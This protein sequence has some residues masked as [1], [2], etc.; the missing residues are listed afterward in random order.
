MQTPIGTGLRGNT[1]TRPDWVP[2]PKTRRDVVRLFGLPAEGVAIHRAAQVM[3]EESRPSPSGP[4]WGRGTVYDMARR[5]YVHQGT[6]VWNMGHVV[7]ARDDQGNRQKTSR[8]KDPRTWVRRANAHEALTTD[9]VAA[10]VRS[11]FPLQLDNPRT[12]DRQKR[13]LA[14]PL[15]LGPHSVGELYRDAGFCGTDRQRPLTHRLLSAARQRSTSGAA[16]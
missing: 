16:H 14:G 10:K 5:V 11:R 9:E 4:R 12:Y 2:D 8:R 7:K 15:A 3:N 6:Y 13:Q 1:K